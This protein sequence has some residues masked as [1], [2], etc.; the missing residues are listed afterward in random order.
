MIRSSGPPIHATGTKAN[1]Q[2]IAKQASGQLNLCYKSIAKRKRHRRAPASFAGRCGHNSAFRHLR[3]K[4]NLFPRASPSRPRHPPG[5]GMT[6]QAAETVIAR[7]RRV[8]RSIATQCH[9]KD[10]QDGAPAK[11]S[12]FINCATHDRQLRH[13][14]R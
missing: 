7:R 12:G 11:H 2:A 9:R 1:P 14:I 13:L 3:A 4:S 10:P 8:S 6:G 5:M